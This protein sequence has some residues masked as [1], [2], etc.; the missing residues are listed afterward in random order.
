MVGVL[1]FVA[2]LVVVVLAFLVWFFKIRDPLRGEDFYK[3]HV[4]QKWPWELTLTPAQEK[5]FMAGLEAFDHNEGGCYPRR[6]DGILH[7]YRPAMLVSLFSLTQ[8]FAAMGQAAVQDPTAAIHTL[9]ARAAQAETDGVLHISDEWMGGAVDI[10]GMDKYE[11]SSAVLSATF[12]A[13][14]ENHSGTGYADEDSGF[15]TTGIL[16][17]MPDQ[18]WQ[19][20]EE[21]FAVAGEPAPMRNRLDVLKVVTSSIDPQYKAAFELAEVEKSK[22]V[23][24]VMFCYRRL[25]EQ[26]QAARP[27]MPHAEPKDV[28]A[29]V[30]ARMVDD[31]MPGCSWAR[32]PSKD[33]HQVAV[34]VL[35]TR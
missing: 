34:D 29:V 21:A 35:S 9:L 23:N 24:T 13:G 10:D 31:G 28:L 19:M 3:F 32:P 11:F 4:E 16:G 25:V 17:P 18:V 8:Q 5:A 14:V 12:S 33:Q 27:Q 30:M 26:Y 6:A 1:V 2:V 15:A 20:Y 7:V 22:Y